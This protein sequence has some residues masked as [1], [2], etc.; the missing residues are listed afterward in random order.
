MGDPGIMALLAP[1]SQ[2]AFCS[3]K[4]MLSGMGRWRGALRGCG[5]AGGMG[6]RL[7]GCQLRGK[8]PEGPE[9]PSERR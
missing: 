7:T 1:C 4:I 6:M 5:A 2:K 8:V 3:L 9:E